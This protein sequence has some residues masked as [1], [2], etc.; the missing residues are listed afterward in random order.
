MD[1]TVENLKLD[2]DKIEFAI[3]PKCDCGCDEYGSLVIEDRE[4]LIGTM[5]S[6]LEEFDC[7][8]CLGVA[9]DNNGEVVLAI[10]EIGSAYKTSYLNCVKTL[11]SMVDEMEIG[12]M[13]I[14]KQVD[15]KDEDGF[16]YD[17]VF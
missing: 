13:V 4:H 2:R 3:P 9:F 6:V 14:L 12:H 17:L 8:K 10:K 1:I 11:G 16:L 5:F 15:E 7:E